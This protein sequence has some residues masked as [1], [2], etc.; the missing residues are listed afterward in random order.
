[1]QIFDFAR[2]FEIETQVQIY[3]LENFQVFKIDWQLFGKAEIPIGK[4][5]SRL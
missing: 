4:P 1:M 5:S 3:P 2:N